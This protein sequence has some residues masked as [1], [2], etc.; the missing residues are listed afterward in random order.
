MP[1]SR[2]CEYA[3][4]QFVPDPIRNET[5]NIGVILR[6]LEGDF[7]AARI[8]PDF[9]RVHCLFPGF[10]SA[11]LKGLQSSLE[12]ALRK[13]ARYFVYLAEETFSQSLRMGGFHGLTTADPARACGELYER[14]VAA[15]EPT[16]ETRGAPTVRARALDELRTMFRREHILEMLQYRRAA[17]DLGLADDPFRFDFH[18]QTPRRRGVVQVVDLESGGGA[19]KELCFMV[20]N[21]RRGGMAI[22]ALGVAA[23]QAAAPGSV[24]SA[25]SDAARHARYLREAGVEL[26]TMG[27]MDAWAREM[28][29]E[30]GA[31]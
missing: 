20:Q 14:F 28:A 17:R 15:P 6:E 12:E 18:F 30:M 9:R 4:L 3:V 13:D 2:L 1:T 29:R 26:T 16:G 8:T 5:V 7:V 31:R 19:I 22:E 10:E 27:T 23:G 21:I 24:A 25:P 11:H